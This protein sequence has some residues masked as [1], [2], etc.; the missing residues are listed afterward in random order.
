MTYTTNQGD[1]WD[2]IAYKQYGKGAMM[3]TL[4]IANQSL[5]DTVIFEAGVTLV[6][7]EITETDISTTLPIWKRSDTL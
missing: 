4:M 2:S 5:N 1:T 3:T 7:P 6:I